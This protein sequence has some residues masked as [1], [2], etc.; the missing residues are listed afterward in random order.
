MRN[1]LP[2]FAVA[3]VILMLSTASSSASRAA[4]DTCAAQLSVDA[5]LIYKASIGDVSPGTDL[6]A[7]VKSKVRS[8][9]MSGRVSRDAAPAAAQAAGSCLKQA[10]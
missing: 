3:I 1:S 8:L 9:V 2:L 6:P 10:L 5:K 7:L 4:A